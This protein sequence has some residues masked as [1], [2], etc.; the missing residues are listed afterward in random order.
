MAHTDELR[1]MTKVARMYYEHSLNQPEIAT[2]LDLSQATISRLLKRAQQEKIVRI[3]VSAPRGIYTDLEEDLQKAYRLKAA[4]VVDCEQEDMDEY[5]LRNLGAA[6]A[7]YVESTI[8]RNEVVGVS[9]WSASMLATIEAMRPLPR[10]LGARVVQLHGGV[11][12]PAAEAHA[13]RLLNR[14]ATLL[15]GEA[16]FLPAPGIVSSADAVPILLADQFVQ[17]TMAHF[18]SM[19]LAL[20]GIGALEP[21]KFIASSGNIFSEAE[22]RVLCRQGAVGNICLR[23]YD[24]AGAP[25][26][27]PLNDRVLSMSLDQLRRVKRVI[28]IAGGRRKFDAIR[29]ALRGNWINVL[30]TDRF[31]A[32]R[33]V[34]EKDA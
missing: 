23:F 24:A 30:V 3:T 10:P 2:Q 28:G 32:E 17:E 25:V 9:S 15:Q 29:G 31:M 20:V 12:N 26:S 18:D 14:L 1:L 16:K 22:M 8:R 19:T 7:F 27:T 34:K 13:N 33:L 5:T 6:A 21:S 11:G 4:I